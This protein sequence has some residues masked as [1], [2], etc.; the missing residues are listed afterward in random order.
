MNVPIQSCFHTGT[1]NWMSYPPDRYDLIRS[2]TR[3][4]CDPFFTAVE[5]GHIACQDLR[6]RAAYVVRDSG[7]VIGLGAHPWL[8]GERLNPNALDE[9]ERM[10]AQRALLEAVDEAEEIGAT[11]MAFLAGPWDAGQREA[12]CEQLLR[13]TGAV[14]RRAQ[15]KGIRVE[16]EVFD[17]DVDKKA[18]IGPAEL[19]ARY[20]ADVRRDYANFGLLVDLSHIPLTHETSEHTVGVLGPYITHLHYGNAVMTPGEDAYGDKHPC[21]GYPHGV[22]GV[23]QLTQYLRALRNEGLMRPQDPLVL[24]MEVAP[25]P[26][27]DADVILTNTKRTLARAWALLEE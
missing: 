27:Q 5:I 17:Y 24:S 6:R 12:G 18:L 8:L 13:T 15:D 1:L 11:A 22:N 7:M 21:F 10:R 25:R 20:A 19:A 9:T 4:A 23:A 2:L 14:C 16:L 26:H 3:I